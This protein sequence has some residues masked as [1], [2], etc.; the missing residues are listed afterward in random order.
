MEQSGPLPFVAR[1]IEGKW[2]ITASPSPELKP[3]DVIEKINGIPFEQF[4]SQVR[5]YI[6][7]SSEYAA[8]RAVFAA[9]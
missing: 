9:G 3:S 6:S 1:T 4:Y 2:F 5:P 8:P 7:A